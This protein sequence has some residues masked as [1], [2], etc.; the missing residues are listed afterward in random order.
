MMRLLQ[1]LADRR[2][3]MSERELCELHEV[4][5]AL[6]PAIMSEL[7]RKCLVDCR[8]SEAEG[9]AFRIN[10]RGKVQLATVRSGSAPPSPSCGPAHEA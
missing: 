8:V 10:D 1:V 9:R 6:V 2:E 5:A 7:M 4:T 3:W